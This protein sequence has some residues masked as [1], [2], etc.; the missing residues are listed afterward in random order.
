[1]VNGFGVALFNVFAVSLRQSIPAEHQLGAV[2]AS[3]RLVALGTLPVGAFAGGLLADATTPGNALWI[4]GVSYLLVS[5][6]LMFSPLRGARTMEESKVLGQEPQ[7]RM[8][9]G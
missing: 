6:W 9:K 5:F 3:Y 7:K 2:T 1:M 4:I 8:S